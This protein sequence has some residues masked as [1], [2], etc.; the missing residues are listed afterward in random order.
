MIPI[1]GVLAVTFASTA[2]LACSQKREYEAA[3]SAYQDDLADIAAYATLLDPTTYAGAD[4]PVVR[5][6]QNQAA[7]KICAIARRRGM[8]AKPAASVEKR[9]LAALESE[10]HE[11]CSADSGNAC[12]D[13]VKKAQAALGE[14]DAEAVKAGLPAGSFVPTGEAKAH[15]DVDAIRAATKPTPEEARL[16]QLWADASAT[17]GALQLA[18][19]A[20]RA[21]NHEKT[22]APV[23]E[24]SAVECIT[25][26][27][28][29]ETS[30]MCSAL[31]EYAMVEDE[32]AS[33]Q[34]TP[35][36]HEDLCKRAKRAALAPPPASMVAKRQEIVAK[37]CP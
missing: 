6:A 36:A 7:K 30:E 32:D 9:V 14:L 16:R 11:C 19:S 17:R 37:H 23:E 5:I 12:G 35:A 29:H 34:N 3:K 31:S 27:R 33:A 22:G 1:R 15:A 20:S 10:E 13:G 21:S 26:K 28:A 4:A 8:T 18:C 25:Q 24:C 2:L